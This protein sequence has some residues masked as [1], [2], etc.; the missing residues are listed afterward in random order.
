MYKVKNIYQENPHISK[1]KGG[2]KISDKTACKNRRIS[3]PPTSSSPKI[4]RVNEE[5]EEKSDLT[6]ESAPH[7]IYLS[8]KL[9]L[10][11]NEQSVR[12]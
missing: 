10:E 3:I 4:R 5:E 11:S 12:V 9:P 8:K 6:I 2:K 7:N 1:R